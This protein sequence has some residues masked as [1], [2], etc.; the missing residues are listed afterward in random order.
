MHGIRRYASIAVVFFLAS[1]HRIYG[2]T[3]CTSKYLILI[4][5]LHEGHSLAYTTSV[6]GNGQFSTA[7]QDE[8]VISWG[9]RKSVSQSSGVRTREWKRLL[10]FWSSGQSRRRKRRA[11]YS[12][13]R[14][15]DVR[16]GCRATY[17]FEE[18]RKKEKRGVDVR[19][20]GF[21]EDFLL[22]HNIPLEDDPDDPRAPCRSLSLFANHHDAVKKPRFGATAKTKQN[23]IRT[24]K[25]E[26]IDEEVLFLPD[27]A[28]SSALRAT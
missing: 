22:L 15:G 23:K 1:L 27:G 21:F 9:F 26:E 13:A 11:S 5:L 3:Q 25:I 2:S 18:E 24:K 17:K 14:V 7:I 8:C 28:R 20:L 6:G 19:I 4:F 16:H 10:T 12:L